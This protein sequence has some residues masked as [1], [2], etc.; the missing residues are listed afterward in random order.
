MSKDKQT[1]VDVVGI[2]GRLFVLAHTP[3]YVTLKAALERAMYE[4]LTVISR[5]IR[6]AVKRIGK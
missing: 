1:S 6:N 4:C 3:L 2:N 5:S